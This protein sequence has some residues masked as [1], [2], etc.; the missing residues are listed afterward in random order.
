MTF[1]FEDQT[2]TNMDAVF[3]FIEKEYQV[4][5]PVPLD[6]VLSSPELL[7]GQAL[8]EILQTLFWL[9]RDLKIHFFSQGR[10]TS[11]L[12]A[13]EM[14]MNTPDVPLF[15][16]TNR[17]ID[18][19]KFEQ[20]KKIAG[21]FIPSLSDAIDQYEFSRLLIQGWKAWRAELTSFG[22]R[23]EQP[24]FPGSKEINNGKLLLDK[25]L[26][27]RDSH[28][29]IINCLKYHSK[30]VQLSETAAILKQF[31]NEHLTFWENFVHQMQI[32]KSHPEEIHKDGEIL[33]KYNRL[34]EIMTSPSPYALV[35]EAK[36]LLA[37]VLDFYQQV[38]R[39]KTE[40]LRGNATEQVNKMIT[41][42][43]GLFDVFENNQEYRNQCL[44]ELR[45]LNKKIEKSAN[46]EE[47]TTLLNDAKDRFVDVIEDI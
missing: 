36:E 12:Q 31:Y 37:H 43:I 19:I 2:S 11:P 7:K 25:V 5:G 13:K 9:A 14:L 3:S 35:N 10:T 40:A 34:S 41:K 6:N 29:V 24:F 46:I 26:E 27:K 18:K 23:A 20:A 16:V 28:S 8:Q 38:E 45:N 44:H 42:L 39:Q 1:G 4:D 32:F 17:P 33:S 22:K 47:I 21:S 15:I 30:M